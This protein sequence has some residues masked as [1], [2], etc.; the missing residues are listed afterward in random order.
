M[1]K[2]IAFYPY[3]ECLRSLLV[4][5]PANENAAPWQNDDNRTHVYLLKS[6]LAK[7][8]L[9]LQDGISTI[10]MCYTVC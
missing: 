1:N 9:N 2:L 4:C 3:E 10:V 5:F 6:H 7:I 8:D